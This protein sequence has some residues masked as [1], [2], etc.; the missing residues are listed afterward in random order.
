MNTVSLAGT[1]EDLGLNDILQ[2][3]ALSRKSGV[4]RLKH[5]EQGL[6]LF[7]RNGEVV[8]ARPHPSIATLHH[9]FVQQ[10]VLA[11]DQ[12][13]SFREI[14]KTKA[15]K[16]I[17]WT[18]FW[19]QALAIDETTAEAWAERYLV[20]LVGHAVHWR[21]GDF[22]FE[23]DPQGVS[24][25]KI[26][27][28]PVFPFIA[29]G[30]GAQYLAMESARLAD[31][32][33]ANLASSEDLDDRTITGIL[34]P[35]PQP[36]VGP[37]HLLLVHPKPEL[38]R[39]LA[40][41]LRTRGYEHVA[42]ASSLDTAIALLERAEERDWVVLSELVMPKRDRS[43]V[44]GGLELAAE[45][46]NH[47]KV[48]SVYLISELVNPEIERQGHEAGVAAF[49]AKPGRKLWKTQPDTA[50]AKLVAA[51]LET[52][53]PPARPPTTAPELPPEPSATLDIN[54]DDP[55]AALVGEGTHDLVLPAPRTDQGVHL[56]R[57]MVEELLNPD[58]EAEVSLLILRFASDFFQRAVFF[59]C[60]GKSV[61][62]LGQVGLSSD[63]AAQVVR[64]LRIPLGAGSVFDRVFNE[65]RPYVGTP[66]D[67]AVTLGFFQRIGD[68][69]PV[70]M[71]LAPVLAGG[72][73]VAMLYADQVPTQSHIRG[74]EALEVF[75][76]QAGLALERA[77]LLQQI[78]E[79][80]GRRGGT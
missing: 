7:I 18:P 12:D 1:L 17:G 63:N 10:H 21:E 29:A 8:A 36:E 32:S 53:G 22:S 79:L 61:M 75:L 3:L 64:G 49:I 70:E 24:F 68:Q 9:F 15:F 57:Q 69:E 51:V 28:V 50:T 45:L 78:R 25:R 27:Q 59:A 48:R 35:A 58:A 4:L 43:G 65:R 2:I 80:G 40:D 71:Y 54:I 62:G 6:D 44:L 37:V 16:P 72:R 11:P 33:A 41:E 52:L 66:P 77:Y 56:L 30:L 26:C 67:D 34:S 60:D 74:T 13:R 73:I 19:T 76:S 20:W 42:V 5:Q 14:L 38:A 47:D 31:E 23:L 46:R 55:L 39:R